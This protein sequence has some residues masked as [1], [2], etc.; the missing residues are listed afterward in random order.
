[1]SFILLIHE[2]PGL[3]AASSQE[4]TFPGQKHLASLYTG[5]VLLKMQNLWEKGKLLFQ[6][7]HLE[8]E[9]ATPLLVPHCPRLQGAH[10]KGFMKELRLGSRGASQARHQA[11]SR[12]RYLRLPQARGHMETPSRPRLSP[13]GSVTGQ[14]P[15]AVTGSGL[16]TRS[17]IPGR[18]LAAASGLLVGPCHDHTVSFSA[19]CCCPS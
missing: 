5:V 14:T 1:M 13:G 9:L 6:L 3:Q 18:Y 19:S 8:Q 10:Q 4:A 11:L 15:S 2:D 16:G 7:S 17:T 12:T